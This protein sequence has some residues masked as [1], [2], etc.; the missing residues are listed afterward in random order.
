MKKIATI[1]SCI[2][3][4]LAVP[5]IAF[6]HDKHH[7]CNENDLEFQHFHGSFVGA[8]GSSVDD[9]DLFQLMLNEDGTAYFN[10]SNAIF[11][12]ITTGTFIPSIGSWIRTGK[13]HVLVTVVAANAL[14]ETGI[15]DVIL[16][17]YT[18]TT[19]RLKIVDKDILLLEHLVEREINLNENPVVAE[20][21]VLQ[22]VSPNVNLY[23]VK[24]KRDDL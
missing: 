4:L 7:S 8:R 14:P 23:R 24:V 19:L 12:P 9:A 21:T 5:S 2:S 20:G 13:K 18:R 15:N 22:D 11:E 6:C 1:I 16:Y 3:M 10:T 17:K